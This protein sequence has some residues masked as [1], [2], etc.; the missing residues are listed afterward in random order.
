MRAIVTGGRTGIGFAC[1]RRLADDGASI[2]LWGREEMDDAARQLRDRGA[3]VETVSADLADRGSTTAAVRDVLAAGPVHILVNNAGTIHR[4]P[5]IEVSE[6]DWDRVLAVNLDAVWRLSRLVGASMV[7][8]GRGRIISIASL[9]SF[10][11]GIN[12]AAY[13]TSK[14]GVVGITRAL[15]NEW[16]GMGVNVN[17]VAPGYIVTNNTAALREDPQRGSDILSR[18]PMGRWGDPQDIAGPVAFLAGPD[19]DY[20]TGHVLV[21][22][23]GWMSR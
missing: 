17:A 23:G 2:V 16:S 3:K 21:A 12:V 13:T 8:Q 19:A 14:H 9:L 7:R 6:E 11:G 20:V 4:E 15:A 1:A 18:I 5:A 22:D 10:Q